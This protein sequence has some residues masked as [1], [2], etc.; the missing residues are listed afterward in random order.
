MTVGGSA[1]VQENSHN[2][3]GV[4]ASSRGDAVYALRSY[5]QDYPNGLPD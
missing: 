4:A 5:A 2:Y 1:T 3:P